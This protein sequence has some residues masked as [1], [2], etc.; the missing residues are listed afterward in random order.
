MEMQTMAADGRAS[1]IVGDVALNHD[2]EF[3]RLGMHYAA[4]NSL[5]EMESDPVVKSACDAYTAGVNAYIE[6]M[7]ASKLPVEFK[8]L[9]FYPEIFWAEDEKK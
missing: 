5:R 3:R 2:R 1:E 7:P 9:G 8:L 4:E 6:S